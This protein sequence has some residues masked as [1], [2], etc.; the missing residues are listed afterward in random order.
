MIIRGWGWG[1]VLTSLTSTSLPLRN[2]LPKKSTSVQKKI[3]LGRLGPTAGHGV[4][5]LPCCSLSLLRCHKRSG[6]EASRRVKNWKSEC[7]PDMIR[8]IENHRF[9]MFFLTLEG[10]NRVIAQAKRKFSL[11]SHTRL[12][13]EMNV[14]V[15]NI[16]WRLLQIPAFC[17]LA[18]KIR[19]SN[20]SPLQGRRVNRLP[21]FSLF[22][23]CCLWLS[24]LVPSLLPSPRLCV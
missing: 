1:G 16:F 8:M 3:H 13:I 7:R 19:I 18:S 12:S 2:T 23:C 21:C 22:S 6:T 15:A 17:L 10:Q 14:H 24:V 5:M 20:S 11:L 4:A 9:L